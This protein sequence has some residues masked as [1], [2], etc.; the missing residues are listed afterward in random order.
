MVEAALAAGIRELLADD[1]AR[2][3]RATRLAELTQVLEIPVVGIGGITSWQDA[4]EFIMA[5]AHAVQV[6]TANFIDPRSGLRIVEGMETFLAGQSIG[7][8]EEIR[9]C[10]H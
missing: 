4:V 9:G 5:G 6:G 1:G 8:W 7:G 10:V 2:A 3:Q